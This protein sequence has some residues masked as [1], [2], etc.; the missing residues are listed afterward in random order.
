VVLF[1]LYQPPPSNQCARSVQCPSISISH[2]HQPTLTTSGLPDR[3]VRCSSISSSRASL[4]TASQD[5]PDHS[6]RCSAILSDGCAVDQ[7]IGSH[8]GY[9]I[10]LKPTCM[11][12]NG[13]SLR[14]AFF[15][16][17][18]STMNSATPLKAIYINRYPSHPL[19]LSWFH[20]QWRSDRMA[21][22]RSVRKGVPFNTSAHPCSWIIPCRC[23]VGG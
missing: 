22:V 2:P 18:R 15:F 16:F 23:M 8:T 6:V 13:L 20:V 21:G 11:F 7:G 5:H 17:N 9:P 14:G 10:C 4:A 3:S 1:P 12:Y 19:H